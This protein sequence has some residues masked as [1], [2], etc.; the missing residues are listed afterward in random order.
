M[1][2]KITKNPVYYV[3]YKRLDRYTPYP[4]IPWSAI[5]DFYPYSS[6][7]VI[8]KI[9][10]FS[11]SEKK[12][13]Y[14]NFYVGSSS[15]PFALTIGGNNSDTAFYLCKLNPKT[16]KCLDAPEGTKPAH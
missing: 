13:I 16:G 10:Y 8:F 11:K 5:K 12:I 4:D 2:R 14:N 3:D 9:G 1:A 6:G 15:N 7:V